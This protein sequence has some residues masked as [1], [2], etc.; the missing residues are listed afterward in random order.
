VLPPPGS[1]TIFAKI[2]SQSESSFEIE[3]VAGSVAELDVRFV[4]APSQ[5][6]GAVLDHGKLLVRFP[7]GEGYHRTTVRFT[8]N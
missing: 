3:G 2:L 8:Y 1:P 5:I 4:R 7:P 6:E